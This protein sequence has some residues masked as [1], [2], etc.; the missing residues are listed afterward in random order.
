MSGSSEKYDNE[1]SP[2]VICG[3]QRHFDLR[4]VYVFYY[5]RI[6]TSPG[7]SVG[8]DNTWLNT[9][10]Q[11]WCLRCQT[12]ISLG[13]SEREQPLEREGKKRC[14]R[15][16]LITNSLL[17]NRKLQLLMERSPPEEQAKQQSQ[18]QW[19]PV[20]IS[21]WEGKASISPKNAATEGPSPDA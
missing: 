2:A 19:D 10:R 1:L 12:L 20:F 5:V 4:T 16:S 6:T 15:Y 11:R 13:R 17:R 18:Q 8:T 7:E 21:L 3:L 14:R 9:R